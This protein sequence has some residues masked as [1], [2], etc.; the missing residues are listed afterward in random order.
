VE[1]QRVIPHLRCETGVVWPQPRE[2]RHS[3]VQRAETAAHQDIEQRCGGAGAHVFHA[4]EHE[5]PQHGMQAADEGRI[6]GRC[7]LD[8][9]GE[10]VAEPV[11]EGGVAVEDVGHE[12]VHQRPQLHEVV[13]QGSPCTPGA[14]AARFRD[15]SSPSG[16]QTYAIHR[17]TRSTD[18]GVLYQ[19]GPRAV[20]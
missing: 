3:R 18:L 11:L 2:K 10:G 14:G 6:D 7:A 5:R 20:Q 8:H 19:R 9:A 13:L 1:H 16:P 17:P 15:Q 12:E 4:A